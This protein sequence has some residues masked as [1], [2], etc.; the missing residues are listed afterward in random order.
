MSWEVKLEGRFTPYDQ[1]TSSHIEECRARGDVQAEITVKGR[2]YIVVLIPP[3]RQQLKDDPTRQRTVRR[4]S[5][6]GAIAPIADN[7]LMNGD[8]QASAVAD[9]D[10]NDDPIVID[11]CDSDSDA[12]VAPDALA[13]SETDGHK[14]TPKRKRADS[15]SAQTFSDL[16]PPSG[17][18]AL[19]GHDAFFASLRYGS[20][21]GSS[22]LAFRNAAAS[23]AAASNATDASEERVR[24]RLHVS[25]AA[26]PDV[27]APAVRAGPSP[28]GAEAAGPA[29]RRKS[30]KETQAWMY[31]EGKIVRAPSLYI[32]GTKYCD[33]KDLPAELPRR[34]RESKFMLLINPNKT[35]PLGL[36]VVADKAWQSGFRS[37]K[38][39][40]VD[41]TCI[42]FGPNDPDHFG[43]DNAKDVI[44]DV[45]FHAVTEVGDKQ[46]RTHAHPIVNIK[47]YSQLHLSTPRIMKAFKKCYND[48][49]ALS[50]AGAPEAGELDIPGHPRAA[51]I[52][53]TLEITGKAYV[54]VELL[55]D[56][57]YKELYA[58]KDN[59]SARPRQGE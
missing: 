52:G 11:L 19:S 46:H 16:P 27:Q 3:M 14:T 2:A 9:N 45:E 30:S 57:K 50:K 56:P 12:A 24:A 26:G 55:S 43:S 41:G 39:G 42:T 17:H 6:G 53:Q 13:G 48:S 47:H 35:V 54:Q 28:L 51:Y 22:A 15:N 29:S 44:I 25:G 37:V 18:D 4:M 58:F 1:D 49:L 10:D 7:S 23:N 36:K 34:E 8:Q 32:N 33:P 38:E 31:P 40:L 20:P 21:L 5:D 59:M